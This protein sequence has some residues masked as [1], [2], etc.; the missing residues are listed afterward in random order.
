[1][2][3]RENNTLTTRGNYFPSVENA[4]KHFRRKMDGLRVV[5]VSIPLNKRQ[6]FADG[7]DKSTWTS[8]VA[9]M[10]ARCSAVLMVC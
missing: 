6:S 2:K 5:S 7:F 3:R 4:V 9:R 10:K 8:E 1:M